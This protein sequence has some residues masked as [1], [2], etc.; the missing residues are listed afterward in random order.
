M[1]FKNDNNSEKN[2]K[3]SANFIRLLRPN[4]NIKLDYNDRNAMVY[5]PDFILSSKGDAPS[6]EKKIDV[7]LSSKMNRV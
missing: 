1:S 3:N 5:R 4:D 7:L 2:S 6:T